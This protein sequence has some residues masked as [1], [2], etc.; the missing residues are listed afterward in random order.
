[1]WKELIARAEAERT[2]LCKH[3]DGKALFTAMLRLYAAI[4]R[5][6]RG[7]FRPEQ[8]QTEEFRQ[9]RRR[10]R[11]LS[12]EQAKKSKTKH[13]DTWTEG[14]WDTIPG[15]DTNKKVLCPPEDIGNGRRAH[16]RGGDDRRAKQRIAA[17]VVQ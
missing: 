4:H 8:Q 13:A 2:V 12:E 14:F 5:E 11:N 10:K 6:M 7:S 1:M 9:Q 15:R 17:A 3:L 16:P